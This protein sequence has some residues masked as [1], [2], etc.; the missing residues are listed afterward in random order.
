MTA[1]H[2]KLLQNLLTWN[3]FLSRNEKEDILKSKI[4]SMEIRVPRSTI[5]FNFARDAQ[6]SNN[7][8]TL[9]SQADHWLTV[10]KLGLYYERQ[11]A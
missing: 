7:V 10:V 11:K 9:L 2:P 8:S 4:I 6:R 1:S 5:T 3:K